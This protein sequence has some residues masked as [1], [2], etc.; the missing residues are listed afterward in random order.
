M[1]RL[2]ALVA[3]SLGKNGAKVEY[4]ANTEYKRGEVLV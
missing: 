2:K 3:T 4:D 1:G